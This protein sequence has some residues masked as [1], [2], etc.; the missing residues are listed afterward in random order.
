MKTITAET[1]FS[2]IMID[3]IETDLG[4]SMTIQEIKLAVGDLIENIEDMTPQVVNGE[5]VEF[6]YER[7]VN[8]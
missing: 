5:T 2:K 7:G 4:G 1:R 3:G 6:H 8:G